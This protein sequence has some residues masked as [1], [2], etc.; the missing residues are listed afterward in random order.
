M[1]Q[2]QLEFHQESEH[3]S[4]QAT[5]LISPQSFIRF[6]LEGRKEVV[7]CTWVLMIVAHHTVLLRVWGGFFIIYISEK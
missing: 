4:V 7:P 1:H 6:I 5:H 2:Q 3:H